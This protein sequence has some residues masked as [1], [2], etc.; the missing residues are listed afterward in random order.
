M[1]L[2]PGTDF[3][4]QVTM[5]T[6]VKEISLALCLM[7]VLTVPFRASAI[8][9]ED[10]F[11]AD[12]NGDGVVNIA[13]MVVVIDCIMASTDSSVVP[14][15]NINPGYV[16]ASE[17]GAVGDGVTDDTQALE[18][19]FEAAF[20]L[21]KA[22]YLNPGTYL[23][24]R[25][26]TLRSGLEVYGSEATITKRKAVTTT[27]ADA[28]E[29]N[30][31]Y[32]DVVDA[33]GFA[34]GDQFV[35]ADPEGENWC[36]HAVVTRITG[37]RIHFLS[38]INDCQPAFLGCVRAYAQGCKVSTSFALLRSWTARFECDGVAI[39]DLTLDGNRVA[40]EP[41]LSANSC[42][43]L[44][45][46]YPGGFTDLSGIEYGNVQRKLAARHLSI[47]NSP[48]DGISD[49]SEGGLAVTDCVI[50]NSARHGIHMGTS[51][52]RAMICS[53]TMTGNGAVGSAVFFSQ[54]VA[55]VMMDNNVIS[56]FKNGCAVDA[57]DASVKYLLIRKNEF[58]GI[59]DEV[60][61][62]ST[63]SAAPGGTLQVSNNTIR[64]L[65]AMLFNGENMDGIVMAGNE[66]KTVTTLPQCA[67]RVVQCNNVILSANKFP[68]S[69]SFST[70]VI[71]TG[72]TN[73]I[74]ASNS[75][76]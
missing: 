68:S 57:A 1:P 8:T 72:T 13:D 74:Q 22:L 50:E 51:F 2:I 60:F 53:N 6:K 30:Q 36:T 25:S 12:V 29:K 70:P 71:A 19:L 21:K 28:A 59:L 34:V 45:A 66:V 43:Y 18:C 27:L 15:P 44:D 42:I 17:Y 67:L 39:N 54:D 64:G 49:L 41:V 56:S 62:F 35:I 11:Y 7:A 16:S 37:N 47:K 4:L 40:S 32:I 52:N 48:G 73:I 3:N 75:W 20:R 63:A 14:N 10:Y 33:S 24:R 55:D 46:Y 26:L 69:A 5:K 38:V 65:N 9:D 58:K 31:N 76:N 23:I 61:A